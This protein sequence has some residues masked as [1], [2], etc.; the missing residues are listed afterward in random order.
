MKI[1]I[2]SLTSCSLFGILRDF[3]ISNGHN[4]TQMISNSNINATRGETIPDLFRPHHFPVHLA[5]QDCTCPICSATIVEPQLS[6]SCEQRTFPFASTHGR[7][8]KPN[9]CRIRATR[10][11]AF[12]R[13]SSG[14]YPFFAY[15]CSYCFANRGNFSRTKGRN[16]FADDDIKNN[17]PE[18]NHCAPASFAAAAT[19]SKSPS[20]SVIPG[21]SGDADTPTESP[22]SRNCF[23]AARRKSRLG[24]RRSLRPANPP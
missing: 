21:M 10:S 2:G 18:K 13:Y 1:W 8:A 17:T 4:V 5:A 24:A 16:C 6:V 3:G 15:H 7:E 9:F 20:R 23:T 11:E 14:A 12:F 19:A 22:A